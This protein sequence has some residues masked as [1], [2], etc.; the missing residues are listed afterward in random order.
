MRTDRKSSARS[1]A[2]AFTYSLGSPAQ[3]THWENVS[4]NESNGS[5]ICRP[6]LILSNWKEFYPKSSAKERISASPRAGEK[7]KRVTAEGDGYGSGNESDSLLEARE[8]DKQFLCCSSYKSPNFV[9]SVKWSPDGTCLASTG[10]DHT[11]R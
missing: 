6:R 11:L 2:L 5:G 4:T 10:A 7:R 8:C 9:T 1:M 3:G